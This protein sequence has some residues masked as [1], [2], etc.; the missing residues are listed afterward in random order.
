VAPFIQ[1]ALD[2]G[3]RY[4]LEDIYD[5]LLK[6]NFQLWVWQEKEILSVLVTQIYEKQCVLLALS[7]KMMSRWIKNLPLIERWAKSVGCDSMLI[8]GRKG[9]SKKLGFKIEGRDD[10][11]LLIMRKKL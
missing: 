5:G 3:S 10:L 8:H 9:W 4:E 2:Q 6:C 11:N 1:R 7:G